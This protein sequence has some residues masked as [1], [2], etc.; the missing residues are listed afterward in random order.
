MAGLPI[1]IKE[2]FETFGDIDAARQMPVCVT[3]LLDPT[4]P[5]DLLD[6][7]KTCFSST[8]ANA[9]AYAAYYEGPQMQLPHAC[10]LAVIVAA[11]SEHTGALAASVRSAGVPVLVLTTMPDIVLSLAQATGF[12]LLEKDMI[13]PVPEADASALPSADDFY[14]EPYP[15][16]QAREGHMR[17]A[18]GAWVVD[19]FKEKRL[20]FALCFPFVRKPLALDAVQAT[21]VQN[22]AIGAVLFIPGAD[23][24]VMTANQ[25]KMVLQIAAA[26][27]Q[28]MGMERAKELA[29][30]VA[31]AFACRAAARQIVGT[32]PG[33]GWALKGGIGFAGTQAMGRAAIAYFEASVGQGKPIEEAMDAAR[34]E[35]ERAAAIAS[36]ETN[37]VSA[38][39][40]VAQ[41]Y[42]QNAASRTRD[43]AGRA[44]PAVQGLVNN[45]AEAA[46]TTPTELGKKAVD[47]FCE[48]T[49][50]TPAELGKNIVGSVLSKGASRNTS[51]G[52]SKGG[53]Y[54]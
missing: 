25:A 10:D 38:A 29:G 46:G 8:E 39:K 7:S 27:G 48:A 24:P 3:L 34:V 37:P 43:V 40:A 33:F 22:A 5:E 21:S 18:M 16:D 42:L 1:D 36:N 17:D 52:T 45:V 14:K 54:L 26:Y 41:N 2:L 47:S 9:R 53:Q 20:A 44:V 35:A 12:P 31:G 4:A 19:V 30:V 28:K 13:A 51:K 50:T 23:M 15:L 11:L 6:F 49:G 32:V